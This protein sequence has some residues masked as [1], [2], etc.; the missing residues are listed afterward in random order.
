MISLENAAQRVATNDDSEVFVDPLTLMLICSILSTVFNALRMWCQ[1]KQNQK[2][3]GNT[4]KEVC[5]NP[6]LRIRRRL[7]RVVRQQMGD[8]QYRRDGDR[9]VT[10]I[11]KAGADAFP[12]ELEYLANQNVYVNQW[13][14]TEQEI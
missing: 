9:V 3:D 14:E 11:L 6:P 5:A 4:I 8:E 1:W 2:A 10:N 12:A 13:G 7:H